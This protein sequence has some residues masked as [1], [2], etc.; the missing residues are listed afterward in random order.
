M[1]ASTLT[2]LD[3][4][5]SSI[6][7]ISSDFSTLGFTA[8]TAVKPDVLP[9]SGNYTTF[10]FFLDTDWLTDEEA[11][12]NQAADELATLKTAS[13]EAIKKAE[14]KVAAKAKAEAAAKVKIEAVAKARADAE[15]E[16]IRAKVAAAITTT[17][18]TG[19]LSLPGLE[20]LHGKVDILADII[21]NLVYTLR[22][23]QQKALPSVQGAIASNESALSSFRESTL[24]TIE[25]QTQALKAQ[26]DLA[27][28]K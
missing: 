3:T 5:L 10:S 14:A 27:C 25:G 1:F 13:S 15:T 21:S 28:Q 24:K 11:L 17:S 4:Y 26:A 23:L 22:D 16:A 2:N 7:P 12:Q 19:I 18:S 6:P 20:S 8:P 9:P